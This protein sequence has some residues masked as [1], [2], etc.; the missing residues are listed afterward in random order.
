MFTQKRYRLRPDNSQ[1]RHLVLANGGHKRFVHDTKDGNNG[2]PF[3]LGNKL[4]DDSDI[5]QCALSIGQA[6]DA[7]EKIDRPRLARMIVTF[8]L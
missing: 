1:G 2:L 5:V 7:I 4:G 3:R 6:H 8:T